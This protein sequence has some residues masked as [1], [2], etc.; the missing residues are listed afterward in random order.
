MSIIAKIIFCISLIPLILIF[1]DIIR[2]R[3]KIFILELEILECEKEIEKCY[4]EIEKIEEQEKEE[5][6]KR[7]NR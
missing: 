3:I 5:N 7:L 1:F 4:K 2:K 6:E